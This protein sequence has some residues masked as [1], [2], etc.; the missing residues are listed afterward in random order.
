[1]DERK[2]KTFKKL[3]F[4]KIRKKYEEYLVEVIKY[5]SSSIVIPWKYDILLTL[6][7]I[8]HTNVLTFVESRI[9]TLHIIIWVSTKDILFFRG[10][11][12][13]SYY[14]NLEC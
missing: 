4:R 2:R 6:K 10:T 12:Q 9:A 8:F 14:A 13:Y 1:M 7:I 11:H 3:D 5:S